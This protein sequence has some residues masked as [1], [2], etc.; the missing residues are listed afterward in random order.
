MD[1]NDNLGM[2]LRDVIPA[3]LAIGMILDEDFFDA[4]HRSGLSQFAC[5]DLP[6]VAVGD[7]RGVA[8]RS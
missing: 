7:E 6:E 5:A 4:K 1:G 2:E 8:N 3:Q